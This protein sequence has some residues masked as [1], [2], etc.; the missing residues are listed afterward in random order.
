MCLCTINFYPLLIVP[1]DI[2]S[3]EIVH[4]KVLGING[5]DIDLRRSNIEK[6]SHGHKN[7]VLVRKLVNLR[8]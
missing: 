3:R 7:Q 5:R 4:S 1:Y 6:V 8:P 2:N